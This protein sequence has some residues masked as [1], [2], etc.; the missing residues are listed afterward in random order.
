MRGGTGQNIPH[1]Q[2]H[3][4][5]AHPT[6]DDYLD[7]EHPQKKATTRGV[8]ISTRIAAEDTAQTS[9]L[10]VIQQGTGRI[11]ASSVSQR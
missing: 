8:Q 7:A 6:D 3:I 5:Q 4:L 2:H 10:K 11:I 1:T 9:L